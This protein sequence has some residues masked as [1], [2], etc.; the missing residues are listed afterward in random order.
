MPVILSFMAVGAFFLVSAIIETLIEGQ[1]P[2][3]NNLRRNRRN[4]SHR[5]LKD[6][7]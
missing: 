4:N 1:S 7:V 6:K 5:R 2:S 3:E